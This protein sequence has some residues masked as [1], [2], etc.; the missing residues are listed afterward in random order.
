MESLCV[1]SLKLLFYAKMTVQ[2]A[3]SA[4]FGGDGAFVSLYENSPFS[5]GRPPL[6]LIF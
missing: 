2:T 4:C 5:D 1:Y 3:L 6:G